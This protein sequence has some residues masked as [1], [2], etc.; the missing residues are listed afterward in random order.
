ML[1]TQTTGSSFAS[2]Q[3]HGHCT[4][5]HSLRCVVV[6]PS[7][8]HFAAPVVRGKQPMVVPPRCT[9]PH[10]KAKVSQRICST[11]DRSLYN[12]VDRDLNVPSNGFSSIEEALK[13]IAAGR[14]VVVL[15]DENRENEGDLIG[16]AE[17][18]TTEAMAYMVE[19]TSGVICISME[20]KDLDRLKLPLMVTSAENEEVGA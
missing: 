9:F 7:A 20:G 15:D 13:D 11:S 12:S 6:A 1:H 17:K 10:S 3:R 5:S 14:F 16:A 2:T 18:M 4:A 8:S 19:Y